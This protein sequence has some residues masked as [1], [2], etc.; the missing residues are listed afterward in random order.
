MRKSESP[1][2]PMVS[3]CHEVQGDVEHGK[4][5]FA[6]GVFDDKITSSSTD[7]MS[8][9]KRTCFLLKKV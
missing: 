6:P 4:F 7:E 5:E 8:Q 3:S 9:V 1:K 2:L